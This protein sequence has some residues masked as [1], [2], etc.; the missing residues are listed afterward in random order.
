VSEEIGVLDWGSVPSGLTILIDPFGRNV[1]CS[2]GDILDQFDHGSAQRENVV[3]GLVVNYATGEQFRAIGGDGAYQNER[4]L[5]AKVSDSLC[6]S[7]RCLSRP[8]EAEEISIYGPLLCWVR[9]LGL[10]VAPP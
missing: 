6:G 1:E 4:P 10:Q 9:E 3:A 5:R 8:L 7:M 2:D